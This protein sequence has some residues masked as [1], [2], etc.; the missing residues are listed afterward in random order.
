MARAFAHMHEART[1]HLGREFMKGVPRFESGATPGRD[2]LLEAF[3]VS[4]RAVSARLAQIVERGD[5][6]KDRSGIALL[7]YLTAHEAQHRGQTLL[8]LKQPGVKTPEEARF[9]IWEHWFRPKLK[10]GS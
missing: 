8:E 10:L 5:R 3:R 6:I 7:G 1:A 4:G 2:E 9:T